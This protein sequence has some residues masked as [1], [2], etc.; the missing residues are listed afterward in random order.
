[1][2][3]KFSFPGTTIPVLEF[4]TVVGAEL[5]Q[6]GYL[7]IIGRDLLRHFQLVYNGVDG[8]WTLAF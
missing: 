6:Q 4:N 5:Q 7:A 2:S 8:I 3:A 1:M